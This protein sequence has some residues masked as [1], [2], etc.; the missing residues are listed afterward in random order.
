MAERVGRVGRGGGGP[1]MARDA[2][3]DPDA[4]GDRPGGRGLTGL[5][6]L[7]VSGLVLYLAWWVLWERS[8]P[9][10]SAARR[11]RQGDA[12]VRL[13]AIR[14]LEHLGPQDPEIAVPAL[15]EGLADPVAMNRGAAAEGLAAAIPGVGAIGA[16]PEEVREALAALMDRLGD[17]E[18]VVRVR[19]SYALCNIVLAWHGSAQALGLDALE[20]EL[21]RKAD[22]ADA[23]VRTA[24]MQGLAALAQEGLRGPPAA[25]HRGAGGPGGGGPHRGRSRPRPVPHRDGPDAPRPDRRDGEGSARVPRGLSRR[26]APS[27]HRGGAE[28]ARRGA[29]LRAHPGARHPGWRGPLPGRRDAGR[30]RARRPGGHPRPAGGRRS[31]G[32]VRAAGRGE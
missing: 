5:F 27:P 21:T 16:G 14:E 17:P 15:I 20:V 8:H 13:E 28:G 23:D 29:G 7:A 32:D 4:R 3:F 19:A 26:A 22:D 1:E 25:S 31:S 11:V 18:A 24:A 9:A 30:A 10:S 6:A 12:A 2:E